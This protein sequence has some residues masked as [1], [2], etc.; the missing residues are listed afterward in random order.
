MQEAS[1]NNKQTIEVGW[2]RGGV[3]REPLRPGRPMPG[4]GKV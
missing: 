1:S 4:K 2:R 3:V